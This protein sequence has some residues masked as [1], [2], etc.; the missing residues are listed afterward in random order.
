M[1]GGENSKNNIMKD[2]NGFTLLEVLV[3]VAIGLVVITAIYM[4]FNSQQDSYA[5]QTQVSATQQNL[6]AAINRMTRDIQMAGYYSNF[7]KEKFQMDWDNL[8][9]DWDIS[10]GN[11]ENIRPLIFGVNNVP[12][13]PTDGIKDRT[14][15]LIII[16][17]HYKKKRLLSAGEGAVSGAPGIASITLLDDWKPGK[18]ARDLDGDGYKDLSPDKYG[19]LV[20]KDLS[21]A[22]FFR[23]SA[24][25]DVFSPPDGLNYDY[26]EGDWIMRA[27]ILY[28]YID[29]KTNPGHPLLRMRDLGNNGYTEQVAENI[30]NLKV[31]YHLSSG[32]TTSTLTEDQVPEVRA[33]EIALVGRTAAPIKG[34]TD[35]K[36]YTLAGQAIP[37]L[38]PN[39]KKYQR[40]LL[41]TTI[42]TRNIGS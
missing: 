3:A 34:Y 25:T 40:R 10:T 19:I 9:G 7:V 13:D 32:A 31:R 41:S 30:E 12:T 22:D 17:G 38:T 5:A 28:Y 18:K 11:M 27:E 35:T 37:P 14:D 2:T 1:I 15:I 26:T 39:E 8:D 4:T 6:R 33:V 23:I 21:H 36:S 42:L 24:D 16:K 20:Q 29:D